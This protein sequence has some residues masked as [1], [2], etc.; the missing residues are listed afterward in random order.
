MP[1][2]ELVGGV[3]RGSPN[4]L[5]NLDPS[6][7]IYPLS[8]SLSGKIPPCFLERGV[9][10]AFFALRLFRQVDAVAKVSSLQFSNHLEPKRFSF[11]IRI[12]AGWLCVT[13][14]PL[15]STLSLV[16][17]DSC[18]TFWKGQLHAYSFPSKLITVMN[19]YIM[20][21]LKSIL[22]AY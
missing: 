3:C 15:Y 1:L 13:Q 20:H 14:S 2:R 6:L 9:F 17:P 16:T 12:S 4:L 22:T 8:P 5:G 7:R 19:I 21:S 18:G 10:G 11:S